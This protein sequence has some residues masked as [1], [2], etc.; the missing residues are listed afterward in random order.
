MRSVSILC[1][2]LVLTGC[3]TNGT[4]PHHPPSTA[5]CDETRAEAFFGK[6]GHAVAEAARKAAHAD[7]VRVI[8]PGDAVTMDFRADRLNLELDADGKIVRARCG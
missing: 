4:E 5:A 3:M 1:A 7:A 6:P 8:G 2:G